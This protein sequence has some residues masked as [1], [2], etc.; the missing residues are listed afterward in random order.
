MWGLGN[1]AGDS[2]NLR[3]AILN[4]NGMDVIL[5]AMGESENITFLKMAAWT[6]TNL[7]RGTP[8]PK[9]KM[10]KGAIPVLGN[11][12]MAGVLDEKEVSQVLWSI[13]GNT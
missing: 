1:I 4:K 9:Y 12:V 11:L 3:D 7:M 6:V 5:K 10:I 13:S 2:T 8:K